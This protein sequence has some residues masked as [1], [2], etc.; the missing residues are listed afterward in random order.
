[1]IKINA[2]KYRE[3]FII[4]KAIVNALIDTGNLDSPE[5]LKILST[6][7]VLQ[8]VIIKNAGPDL[9]KDIK[10]WFKYIIG[11]KFFN[12]FVLDLFVSSEYAIIKNKSKKKKKTYSLN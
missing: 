12:S 6:I 11:N 1:M 2:Y 8:Y 4:I 10:N 7:R 3:S 5:T 9:I